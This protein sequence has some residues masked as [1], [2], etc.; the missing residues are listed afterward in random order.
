MNMRWYGHDMGCHDIDDMTPW[1]NIDRYDW[2]WLSDIIWWYMR[3]LAK[4]CQHDCNSLWSQET[5]TKLGLTFSSATF[6][7]NPEEV[8]YQ[9]H[10]QQAVVGSN[11]AVKSVAMHWMLCHYFNVN[12][13]I[14]DRTSLQRF[15]LGC[16]CLRR[17]REWKND[18][19]WCLH[20]FTTCSVFSDWHL[21]NRRFVPLEQWRNLQKCEKFQSMVLWE[22]RLLTSMHLDEGTVLRAEESSCCL[23]SPGYTALNI[24]EQRRQ[25]EVA[26]L[27][28]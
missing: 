1:W 12:M 15:D 10:F 28:V 19:K 26:H 25:Q 9:K 6:L 13:C 14:L 24:K 8:Q 21:N 20:V 16:T 18:G 7:R 23:V 27:S 3:W 11:H 2:L 5:W 4:R 22:Q 17:K